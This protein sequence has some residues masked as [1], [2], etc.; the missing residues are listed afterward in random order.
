M[1]IAEPERA[2]AGGADHRIL[3]IQLIAALPDPGVV[4][5]QLIIDAQGAATGVRRS[6]R[7]RQHCAGRHD[8]HRRIGNPL[9]PV[10]AAAKK[11]ALSVHLALKRAMLRVPKNRLR[12]IGHQHA[13]RRTDALD[14]TKGDQS[15]TGANVKERHAGVQPRVVEYAIG[16]ALDDPLYRPPI[17]GVVG[18]P[19]VQQP[20]RPE[21]IFWRRTCVHEFL[22]GA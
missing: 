18:M 10:R 5:F 13:Q 4:V 6:A 20:L 11:R 15:V 3:E 17:F 21:V 1:L 9:E 12:N 22:A 14:G 2:D 8:V 16:V 7:G 19:A